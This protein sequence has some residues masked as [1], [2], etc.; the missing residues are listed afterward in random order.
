M[1]IDVKIPLWFSS[2]VEQLMHDM[3]EYYE[4]DFM[5]PRSPYRIMDLTE[6]LNEL[7]NTTEVAYDFQNNQS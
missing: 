1:Y 7:V 5:D 4:S 6:C 3:L 2:H